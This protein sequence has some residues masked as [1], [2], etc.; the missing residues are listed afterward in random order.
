MKR[1]SKSLP[2]AALIF[3]GAGYGLYRWLMT[4]EN[5]KGFIDKFHISATLLLVLTA[6]MVVGM[7]ICARALSRRGKNGFHFPASPW[8]AMGAWMAAIGIGV[9]SALELTNQV[10]KFQLAA[11][12]LGILAALALFYVGFCC[13]KGAKINVLAYVALCIYFM[14]HLIC[15][16]R[17]WGAR[18]QLFAYC[19]QLLAVVCAMLTAYHRGNLAVEA[20][21]C[22]AYTYFAL[23]TIFFCVICLDKSPM[24][25]GVGL[26]LMADLC[27]LTPMPEPVQE[28]ENE[29]E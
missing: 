4:T 27:N 14:M 20:G 15:M 22:T 28:A 7:F 8:S 16:Y 18:P 24:Y 6:V 23:L 3:G 25:V 12:L 10:D 19:F 21:K 5:E 11:C 2:W 26:W 9:V 17:Y 29:A 13:H 1:F